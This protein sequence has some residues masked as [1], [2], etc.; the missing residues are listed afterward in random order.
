MSPSWRPG[1][2]FPV[3][4][5]GET[6]LELLWAEARATGNPLEAFTRGLH[7]RYGAGVRVFLED[8]GIRVVFPPPAW[9]RGALVLKLG[10]L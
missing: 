9:K 4:D 3:E 2:P 10:R 8:A 1:S 6:E 5:V 7:A